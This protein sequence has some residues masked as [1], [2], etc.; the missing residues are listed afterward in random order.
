MK[1]N[2]QFSTIVLSIAL[3]SS[4]LL[5]QVQ[6]PA[7]IPNGELESQPYN[8]NIQLQQG[9]QPVGTATGSP[10]TMS[11]PVQQNNGVPAGEHVCKTHELNQEHYSE[12]GI[13]NEFN[14]DYLNT[15]QTMVNYATPKT[16]GVNEIAIIFHVVHNPN[17]PAENVSNAL[18]MQVYDDLV[19]DFLLQNTD[20]S[21]VRPGFG[22]TPVDANINFCLA[23]QDPFGTPLTEVGVVRVSTTE[24]W[25]D[26]DN[27]E[28]NKMKSSVTGGSEIWDRNQYLNVWICDISNGASSGTAGYAYRPSPSF[29]PSAA[30]DGIVLDYNLGMNNENVL[31]HEVGHY[32]GLDHTWGGSGGCGNDD[33]FTDSPNT[34]GPSFNYP[35]SCGPNQETCA[36]IQTQYENY[37]D[38][39]N[40]TCMF[41][42]EQA[43][44]M[45]LILQGIRGSLL[46]SPG[47]DPV[48]APPV[49]DFVADIPDPIIIPQ[50]GTVN[51]ISTA[52]NAPT[53]WT[54]DFSGGSPATTVEDPSAT[55]NTVGTYTV[56][57]TATN[58]FGTGSE[59]KT[60]HVQVVPPSTGI[61]CD[62]LRNWDPADA[63]ANGF[64]YYNSANWGYSPGHGEFCGA[65]QNDCFGLQYAERL[66]YVGSAEVR[67]IA[68]PFFIVDDQSGTGT[69]V[70]KVY[71]DAGGVPG[72]ELATETINLADIDEGFWN[73]FEFS[74]PATVTGNFWAGFEL[75]YGTPQD[76]VLIGMTDTQ[77][78]GNDSYYIDINGIGWYD[79][80]NVGITGSIALDVM[81]SNGP[82]P[83]MNFTVSTDE[84]CVGGEIIVN[85]SGSINN[86]NYEWFV[87]DE[88]YTT[89]HETSTAAGNTFEF[90]YAP[91]DYSIYL[92]GEGSCRTDGVFLPVTINAPV[93]ATVTPTH[94]TCGNNNGIITVTAPTGGDGTYYYSLD[95]V[96]YQTGN[97]FSNIAPGT[98]TVYV[99]TLGDNCEVSYSITI[100]P[101]SEASAT[102][103]SNSSVCPGESATITAGGGVNYSWYDGTNLI[104]STASTVVTPASSTQYECIV[105]DGSGCQATVYTTVTVNPLPPAPT[106]SASGSTTICDGSSVD[107][108]SSYP[109]DNV[110]STGETSSEITV[111]SAGGYSVTYTDGNGCS[112][113]SGTTT[114]TVNPAPVIAS[115]SLTTDPSACSTATGSIEVTGSGTGDISWTGTSTGSASGVTLPYTIGTL[116]AGSYN[117]TFV[118]GLGCT[119]NT[120]NVAL[121]DPTPPATPNISA[122]GPLTFCTGSSV[123]LTSSEAS[124]NTWSTGAT[125]NSINVTTSGTYS[126]TY[127]DIN[128]CSA[129]SAGTVI[130]V[131]NNPT[132]PT[133]TPSGATTFCD[134]GSVNLTSSQGSGNTWSTT[135]TTQQI[136]VTT[137]GNYTVTYTN[138]NG[139]STTST[140][141]G[142]T[143]NPVPTAPTVTPSGATTFCAGG[144]VTLTSSEASGNTWSTG[145]T[146]N[147]INVTNSGSYTVTYTDGNGCEAISTPVNVTVNANPTPPTITASGS[148]SI[149]DGQ[150]VTL[151]SSE[152]SGNLWSTGVTTNSI[153]VSTAGSYSV[154]Y[155]DGNGCEATS[156]P[157]N[158]T[159]NAN[160]AP[161]TIT[162]SGSTT[163]CDGQDVTLT[164]SE[165]SGNMWSTGANTNSINVSS[166]GSYTV[167]FTD[168]NGCSASST[169]T[170]V[171]V[172]P[173]PSVTLSP[174]AM[175]CENYSPI[176]L[177]G[178]TPVGGV[179]SGTG[180]TGGNFDPG[181]AGIG[182]HTISYTFTDGNGCEGVATEDIEVDGCISLNENQLSGV[183]VYPNPTKD[184][185]HIELKG[186]FNFEIRDASGRLI[187]F[188]SNT[189][190]IEL[191]TTSYATGVYFVNVSSET[192][193]TVIKVVK[194]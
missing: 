181:V 71:A 16:S 55:F 184:K 133:I 166:S 62:T 190:S 17:N 61:G 31:T 83:E 131:N 147:S 137:S 142:V 134:G 30:I 173:N 98:Y 110:W 58:A 108:T 24:D 40:C 2:K 100:N 79:A 74:T 186:D 70:A 149:C 145:A 63:S 135:E 29:L 187:D 87:T 172:N 33:G 170:D 25:Y 14:E 183:K 89:T 116:T 41:T 44:Y 66:T 77:T 10:T 21:N 39:A 130:T 122:D 38:Y 176:A 101:S 15:A 49:V 167:T 1:M 20:A 52:T 158:V 45:L 53:S 189:N 36:G 105:T 37:M 161:P 85:G 160:P 35:G 69:L 43:D 194:N 114:I 104:A 123:N 97:T 174:F 8:G 106:I 96:N 18:I 9:I 146:T 141:V 121:T 126:V 107:L 156:T 109:T 28:E 129:S 120:L 6:L 177:S 164:S 115:G 75:F 68:M 11:T 182:T 59:T 155:T 139:C 19:E 102:V 188:G 162:A 178:G 185:L 84:V 125:G 60:D 192:L 86:S 46:L 119:S 99:A 171:T 157:V 128:G 12:R 91:G 65:P 124:G 94:T 82:D 7:S 169:A 73:E 78:G 159:V 191:N 180:V 50:G 154:T 64:Y 42:Q 76:T 95:G 32:L 13:Q 22:F 132:A 4:S 118:D 117:I 175:V 140:P 47:C 80:T 72:A 23:T 152:G 151:T 27:G 138:A 48:N 54:W 5:A 81:L 111:T 163:I 90:P 26:S 51:F 143:V 136:S 113:T 153:N 127:T 168:G 93:S 193:N 179:Y 150:D 88:P 34:A 92:F 67:R 57:H 3:M 144:D 148:T 165:G 103:S 112:S 56:T